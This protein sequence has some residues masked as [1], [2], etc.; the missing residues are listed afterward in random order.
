MLEHPGVDGHRGEMQTHNLTALD[1][2]NQRQGPDIEGET[3]VAM[4]SEAIKSTNVIVIVIII[5]ECFLYGNETGPQQPLCNSCHYKTIKIIDVTC[6]VFVCVC[7]CV[8][9]CY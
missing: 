5:V 6:V 9:V 2:F 7:V 1:G 8:C 4:K 3:L